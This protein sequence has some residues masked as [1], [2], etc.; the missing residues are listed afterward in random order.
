MAQA[1]GVPEPFAH[2]T[3]LSLDVTGSF[4]MYA[5]DDYFAPKESLLRPHAPEWREGA[6]TE[7]GKWMD[8]WESARRRT[9]GHDWAVVRL[10]TAGRIEGVVC[11]TT[12]FKGNAPLEVALE[13]CDL[14]PATPL[15]D[16]LALPVAPDAAGAAALGG[17]AWVEVLPRTAVKPDFANVLRP[18][19]VLPRASHV[20]LRIFPDG[21]VSRLRLFGAVVPDPDVFWGPGSLDLVA[22]ENGGTVALASDAFFGPPANLLL[23]GRGVNMGDGWET[24]RRR[25]P[26]SDWCVLRLGRRGVLHWLELDTHFFKGNAPQATRI[27]CLDA[28]ESDGAELDARVRAADGWDVL[29]E[30]TAIV[31]HR[32]HRLVPVRSRPVTHL[33]VH[34][35][36]HGGVNR[37]RAWGQAVDTPGESRALAALHALEG[38]T[39]RD[40]LRSFCASRAFADQLAGRRPFAS[41]RDLVAAAGESLEGLAEADL[42]EAFAAHPRLGAPPAAGDASAHANWSRREQGALA[43]GEAGLLERLQQGN[44]AYAERFGFSFIAFANGRGA[45]EIVE[46]LEER[47]GNDRATEIANAAREQARI[48]RLRIGRWL[49]AHG[50]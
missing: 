43:A 19:L 34:I 48:T 10:G 17:R 21:G 20:R 47:L 16:L 15:A 27:E 31:Q 14:P 13:A 28:G 41:V 38:E 26:G 50:A 42:L 12:H 39:L 33:R 9:P 30:R 22:I 4:V 46:L 32:R 35:Y 37:L 24:K 36:P 1:Y 3:E 5:T 29:V 2:L 45:G 49:T 23:P 6:Y 11:D 8:G 25:T 7:K 40:V 18:A 44:A